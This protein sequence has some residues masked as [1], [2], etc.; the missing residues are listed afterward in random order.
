MLLRTQK[1]NTWGVVAC[2]EMENE[3][4]PKKIQN[5]NFKKTMLGKGSPLAGQCGPQVAC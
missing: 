4:I 3:C 1:V 2:G 5:Q